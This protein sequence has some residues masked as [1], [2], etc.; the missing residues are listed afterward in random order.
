MRREAN[1]Q[2]L[3]RHWIR[4][5]PMLHSCAFELKQ[6]TKNYI[7]FSDVQEH[8]IDAL[9]AAS[10]TKG[11]LYKAPDD[12]RGIKPF[13]MF[14]LKLADSFVVIRYPEFFCLIKIRK[15]LQEKGRSKKKSLT[16]TRARCISYMFVMI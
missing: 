10:S 2:T 16:A 5:Y 6:T 4:A 12:S 7:S 3:F 9:I 15:F 14:Y 13:D 8:Q 1:F 11:L